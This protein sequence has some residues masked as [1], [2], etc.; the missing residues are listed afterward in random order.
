MAFVGIKIWI[1]HIFYLFIFILNKDNWI[2]RKDAIDLKVKSRFSKFL[3]VQLD[4]LELSVNI[5]ETMYIISNHKLP[6]RVRSVYFVDNKGHFEQM[7]NRRISF[8]LSRSITWSLCTIKTTFYSLSFC[9][10]TKKRVSRIVPCI[11]W[12]VLSV[13]K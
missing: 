8:L 12:L 6:N 5:I 10:L 13:V 4:I 11:V 7:I 2:Y 3:T 1:L 9:F